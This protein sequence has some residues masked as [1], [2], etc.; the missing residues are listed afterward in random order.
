MSDNREQRLDAIRAT[1]DRLMKLAKGFDSLRWLA[2][3]DDASPAFLIMVESAGQLAEA[4]LDQLSGLMEILWKI[5][6]ERDNAGN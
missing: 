3:H 2:E 6:Q 5:N 1:A 4:N